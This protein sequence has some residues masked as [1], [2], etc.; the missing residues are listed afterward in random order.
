VTVNVP[1]NSFNF[2]ELAIVAASVNAANNNPTA[3]SVEMRAC[4]GV[5]FCTYTHT[6]VMRVKG[7]S[8]TT[9]TLPAFFTSISGKTANIAPTTKT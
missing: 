3:D 5:S 9:T 2:P 7:T 6:Y 1:L 8:D 4:Q